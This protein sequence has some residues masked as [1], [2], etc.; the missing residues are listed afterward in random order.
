MG[1]SAAADLLQGCELA[2][3][4][5]GQPVWRVLD[6]RFDHGQRFWASWHQWRADPQRPRLLHFVGLTDLPSAAVDL[7]RAANAAQIADADGLIGQ[8]LG[9]LPGFHRFNLDQGQVLL[10][11][12]VGPTAPT[13]RELRFQ[14][15][16]LLLHGPPA[17]SLPEAGWDLWQVKA[18]ARCAR[19]GSRLTLAA[20]HVAP[21][22]PALRQC[23]FELDPA[24][25]NVATHMATFQPRWAI[26]ATRHGPRATPQGPDDCVVLG[27]GLAGASVAAALARRGWQVQVLDQAAAP[28][29][30]AS[31]LPAGLLVPHVSADDCALSRLSRCGLRL[32]LQQAKALLERGQDWDATGVLQHDL[33]AGSR[34]PKDWPE[35][36]LAWSSPRGPAL[37]APWQT[38]WS[39]STADLWHGMAAWIK[40]AA[41]VQAWL[42]SPGVR[43][44]G[45]IQVTGLR[46]HRDAWEL[47]GADHQALL[48]TRRL[49]LAHA[50]GVQPL[51]QG[52]PDVADLQSSALASLH[53]VPGQVSWGLRQDGQS[54]TLPPFPVNGSG[55]LLPAVPLPQGMAW[56]AGATYDTG[57]M[58]QPDPQRD[59]RKNLARLARLLP[60]AATA[61]APDFALHRVQSWHSAR[62][63]SADRLPLVGPVHAG[64]DD[65][66]WVCTGMGSRGLSFAVLCAELLAARWGAE[67]WPVPARLARALE[68]RR[69]RT[70]AAPNAP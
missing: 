17:Q 62:C 10:T 3:S 53:P 60:A 25:A 49:V 50:H 54:Q 43:F 28:A 5:R 57:G 59:H 56:L 16:T 29:S 38:G 40:P 65:G 18:L 19:R 27:A 13:L 63:V 35:Q 58:H 68:P 21:I 31:S 30:G 20:D 12:C 7:H 11:L 44:V 67:P 66:L 55:S 48:A 61:L 41:L 2:L 24:P 36:G 47:L 4:W 22:L 70:G 23:G 52:C 9:L 26:K 14:A 39:R 45:G 6:T 33:G 32:T 42:A 8:W 37:Q 51:L 64:P 46:R 69:G 34:L 1:E 15:D